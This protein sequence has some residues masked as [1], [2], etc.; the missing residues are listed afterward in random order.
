MTK[1]YMV[2][3]IRRSGNHVVRSW[4]DS[5]VHGETIRI[6][7]ASGP[8]FFSF[9]LMEENK[10]IFEHDNLV[11]GI[12]EQS[13]E[14]IRSTNLYG[15]KS[16]K[17]ILVLRD[18]YNLYASR[19]KHY[20]AMDLSPFNDKFISM[21]WKSYAN[22]FLKDKDLIKVSYNQFVG[23]EA[24]RMKLAN[25]LGINYNY[26]KDLQVM[27][28]VEGGTSTGSSFSGLEYDGK[29]KEMKV[30]DRWRVYKNDVRYISLFD[31]ETR[32]LS[33]RIFRFNPL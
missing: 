24:Y 3:G 4:V 2:F 19:I 16:V 32:N 20:K 9:A 10:D 7:N 30:N 14:A 26:H 5:L 18:P 11:M 31:K 8:D 33:E 1:A 25:E 13:M 29:A 22:A 12:E 27:N 23:S 15:F 21:H 28:K 17:K 6:I